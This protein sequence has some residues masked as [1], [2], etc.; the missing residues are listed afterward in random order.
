M[1]TELSVE[2]EKGIVEVSLGYRTSTISQRC[3][4]RTIGKK[5]FQ[6]RT[7]RDFGF[8]ESYLG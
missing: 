3:F 4:R 8:G 7:G 1:F 2:T 5:Y 6:K